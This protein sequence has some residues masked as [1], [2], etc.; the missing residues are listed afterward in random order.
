[1]KLW[2]YWLVFAGLIALTLA[3]V[4]A[5]QIDMG[6]LHLPIGLGI[7]G[8]KAGLVLLFFMHLI[9][10]PRLTWIVAIGCLMWLALLIGLTM[11]DVMSRVP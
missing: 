1:M 3:T 5:A 6:P 10:S 11:T 9:R 2:A 4:A 8:I 7:A